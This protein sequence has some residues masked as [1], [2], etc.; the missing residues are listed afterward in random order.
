MVAQVPQNPKTLYVSLQSPTEIRRLWIFPGMQG[1]LIWCALGHFSLDDYPFYDA[2]S[3]TWGGTELSHP[4]QCE[5]K[6]INV[7]ASLY[8]ALRRIR[9]R[10][11]AR[12]L[13]ADAICIN[14][15]STLKKNHQIRLMK[16]IYQQARQVVVYLGEESD[17]SKLGFEAGRKLLE[18]SKGL[19]SPSMQIWTASAHDWSAS[20]Q[21]QGLACASAAVLPSMVYTYLGN[22]GSRSR[23]KVVMCC[24]D[25]TTD[26]DFFPMVALK[27]YDY[28]L[29]NMIL[30]IHISFSCLN[31]TYEQ[32]FKRE[33]HLRFTR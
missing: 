24:G 11:R 21:T 32:L 3:Y 15:F 28:G 22:A 9:Q 2:L 27:L 7:T 18:V 31:L 12:I 13:W 5:K 29:G 4:I 16:R 6:S 8:S 33:F 17:D 1:D 14:Q 23:E 19:S 20:H 30:A 25:Q 26:F 10:N